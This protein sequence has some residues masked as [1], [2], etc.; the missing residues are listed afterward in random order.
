MF[1]RQRSP[2]DFNEEIRLHI[3]QEERNLIEEGVDPREARSRARRAFGNVTQ[4]QERYYEKHNSGIFSHLLRELQQGFRQL[5]QHRGF[6]AL[7]ILTLAL[8]IGANTALFSVVH[9]ILIKDLPYREPER[10]ARIWMD[11]RRLQIKEDWSSW[12]NYVDYKRLGTSFEHMTAFTEDDAT[13]TSDGEAE[14]VFGVSNEAAMFELLGV[15]PVLGRL[16][17]KEEE[18]AGKGDVWVI[19]HALWQRR[20]G[21][22]KDVIGKKIEMDNRRAIIIGVMPAGFRFPA[23]DTDYWFPLVVRENQ[24]SRTGYWLQIVAK[25]KPDATMETAKAELNVAAK[26]LE[27]QYPADNAG[28]GIYVNPLVNHVVG[29]TR[30]PL[31]MLLGAVGCVLLIACVNVAGLMV[32][33]AEARSREVALRAA[34]GAGRG[35]II[36][37]ILL[38]SVALT[39]VAGIVGLFVALWSV[40]ALV[41]MAPKDLPRLDEIR[42][43]APVLIFAFLTTGLTALLSGLIPAWRTSKV[44]LNLALRD[45]GRSI[46]SSLG[47]RRVRAA[48]VIS[49]CVL[50]IILLA[51]AGLLLRSL[52][53]LRSVDPGFRTDNVLTVR[54]SPSRTVSPKRTQLLDFH[55]RVAERIKTL[56]GVTG[57]GMISNLLLND[58][59]NTITFTLEDRPPFPPADVIEAPIDAATPE[60]FSTMNVKLKYGRFFD[61]RDHRDAPM[62]AIVNDSFARRYWPGR[63]PVGQ[64]FHFGQRREKPTWITIVGVVE[65]MHR[66]G[67]HRG[68]RLEVFGPLEQA[69]FRQMQL[70]VATQGDPMALARAVREEIRVQ[71]RLATVM[72]VSTVTD[73]IGDSIAG[74]KFVALLLALLAGLALLLAAVGIFGLMHQTVARRAQ[75]IGLRMALGAAGREVVGMVLREGL[76]LAGAGVVLGVI[77]ALA[78]SRLIGGLLFG[79]GPADPITYLGSAAFLTVAAVLACWLPA[80]RASHVDP[81]VALRNE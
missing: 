57:V 15:R 1:G 37:M 51:G 79:V 80:Y 29:N 12:L 20:F 7:A 11:N 42:I 6:A 64:R 39:V 40:Q 36:R 10:L 35:R 19:S 31:L 55:H 32:S 2:E 21:A 62:T 49:E 52:T 70:L 48:L 63:D 13:L 72:K 33:R 28:Y 30:T 34:L 75:E 3:E 24:K 47:A 53:N 58:A 59:P 81:M 8:G 4:A 66:L 44:D 67:L 26:Q 60:F 69:G 43:N 50:A 45:G 25:L 23:K 61:A 54:M 71:D 14:H 76:V 56:P 78:L 77:G 65:D 18:T 22:S 74:R 41:L 38:E 9:A 27:Q 16:F 73:E 46:T 68:S 5:L 17:T